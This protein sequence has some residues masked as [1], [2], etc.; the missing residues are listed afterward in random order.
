MKVLICIHLWF[1]CSFVFAKV[2]VAFL[3]FSE[4]S[5]GQIRLRTIALYPILFH[6]PPSSGTETLKVEVQY[7]R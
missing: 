5:V 6:I 7:G 4:R 2:S 3:G 1:G